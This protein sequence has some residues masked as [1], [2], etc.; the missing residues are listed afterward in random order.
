MQHGR[1]THYKL[2]AFFNPQGSLTAVKQEITR[3][4]AASKDLWALDD[5]IPYCEVTKDV[6]ER[7]KG[8]PEEGVYLYNL[9]LE[10]HDYKRS[11]YNML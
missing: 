1:L 9:F 2:N 6:P 11:D 5:V 8:P 4:H 3:T 7:L 10:L